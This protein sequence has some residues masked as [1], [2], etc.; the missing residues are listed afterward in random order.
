MAARKPK[1]K[2]WMKTFGAWTPLKELQ[3]HFGFESD[4]VVATAKELLGG[5]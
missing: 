1:R 2:S 5:R 3:R 4:Q